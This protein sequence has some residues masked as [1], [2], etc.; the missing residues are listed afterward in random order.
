[1]TYYTKIHL[2]E[3]PN[4][5]ES[6][7]YDCKN[8]LASSYNE[9][10]D[11]IWKEQ[12]NFFDVEECEYSKCWFEYELNER[13]D[14]FFENLGYR[15]FW[16]TNYE[17]VKVIFNWI[18]NDDIDEFQE[19]FFD[20]LKEK[21]DILWKFED[22]RFLEIRK[23]FFEEIYNLEIDLRESIS[24][25]FLNTYYDDF[26][27]LKD[28]NF[29]TIKKNIKKEDLSKSLE[30]EFFYISF[31]KYKELLSL[32]KLKD[33]EKTDL[34][35]ESSSFNEW[36]E[37]I[38]NRWINKEFYKD[39]ISSISQDLNI[40]EQ[41]RN[42]IMHNHSINKGLHQN[43]ESSKKEINKK[44][45][46]FRKNHMYLKWNDLDL[47]IWNKYTYIAETNDNFIQWKKYELLES[48]WWDTIFMWEKEKNSMPFFDKE[49]SLFWEWE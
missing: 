23:E 48:F 36:K 41:V 24:F 43:Y 11:V 47:I 31:S 19:Y 14:E 28:L 9:A 40:L 8:I 20:F 38:F 1:M 49:F 32:K 26:N 18:S 5:S 16:D 35:E 7:D 21:T 15:E 10:L 22:S 44:I 25:I 4:F 34:L 29:D 27:L 33:E 17:I 13:F 6:K 46:D 45:E 3:D 39:F 37:K 12:E 30:N 2:L 42:A